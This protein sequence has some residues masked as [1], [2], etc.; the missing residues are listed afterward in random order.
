ML[1]GKLKVIFF[2]LIGYFS[3]L[4]ES[5]GK[6][7]PKEKTGECLGYYLYDIDESSGEGTLYECKKNADSCN[8]IFNAQGYYKVTD[9]NYHEEIPYIICKDNKCKILH[10]ED[11]KNYCN[12][13]NSGE[14]VNIQLNNG[15][16]EG[17]QLCINTLNLIK[18]GNNTF[19]HMFNTKH[20]RNSIFSNINNDK[21][22]LIA[23]DKD[24]IKP[25]DTTN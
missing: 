20:N 9:I 3:L 1:Y 23:I 21:Y 5:K 16:S 22:I 7:N 17:V 24:S 18:F 13:S 25:M 10:I 4:I 6:C 19:I 12:K 11:M 15:I 14:L 8:A 2:I